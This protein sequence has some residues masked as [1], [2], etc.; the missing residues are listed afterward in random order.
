LTIATQSVAEHPVDASLFP[1]FFDLTWG[2]SGAV[3]SRVLTRLLSPDVVGARYGL[4]PGSAQIWWRYPQRLAHLCRSY[5][6]KLW[7]FLREGRRT[8]AHAR[9]RSQLAQFLKPFEG[10]GRPAATDMLRT[11]TFK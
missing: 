4:E 3:R 5:G 1:D 11:T 8:V 6:P 2:A 7:Q 10:E 9:R